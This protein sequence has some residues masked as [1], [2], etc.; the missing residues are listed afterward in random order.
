MSDSFSPFP[1]FEFEFA[2]QTNPK[3]ETLGALNKIF[4]PLSSGQEPF[5]PILFSL[6]LPWPFATI[7]HLR[8]SFRTPLF[9]N[10]RSPT[11][12]GVKKKAVTDGLCFF[13]ARRT[14]GR[15]T[16]IVDISADLQIF[17]E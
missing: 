16:H 3:K 2:P 12:A 4:L 15:L 5:R 13:T 10:P 17:E 6:P 8:G 7:K 1:V 9:P 11:A 14:T